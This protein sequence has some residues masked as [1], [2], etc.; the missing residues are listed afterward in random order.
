M[1]RVPIFEDLIVEQA[2]RHIEMIPRFEGIAIDRLDYSEFFNYDRDD[3]VSFVPINGSK[4]DAN[5]S[6][7]SWG[8]ARALRL[9]YRHTFSRLHDLL[10][11]QQAAEGRPKR[12]MF[13]NCNWLCRLDEMRHFDGSFSE[14]AALNA[15]AWTGLRMP[16][17]LWTYTLDEKAGDLDA[18]FQQHLLMDVYPMAPSTLLILHASNRGPSPHANRRP[19]DRLCARLSAGASAQE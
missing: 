4:H 15:V 19:L 12:A 5:L 3:G 7:W 2:A 14:G 16:T 1:R 9:S 10:H 13:N 6:T 8:P 11:T 17:I 18:Y